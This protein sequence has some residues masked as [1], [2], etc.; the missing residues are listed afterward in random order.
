MTAI[1]IIVLIFIAISVIK[2]IMLAISPA[3]WYGRK[4]PLIGLFS[5]KNKATLVSL[6]LGGII[7]F[8]LLQELSIVQIFAASIFGWMI[9][10]FSMAPFSERLFEWVK[11]IAGEPRFFSKNILSIVVWIFL[12]IWVLKEIFIGR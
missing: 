12:I 10:M 5:N 3:S 7:L 11:G 8:Y 4:N 2:L 9:I 6:I 1:E